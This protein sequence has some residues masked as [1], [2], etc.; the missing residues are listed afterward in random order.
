MK[1]K[2]KNRLNINKIKE[3]AKIK[4]LEGPLLKKIIHKD[5][6]SLTKHPHK[7]IVIFGFLNKVNHFRLNSG[8]LKKMKYLSQTWLD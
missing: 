7:E 2:N 4:I 1:R 3:D 8:I 5:K 6:F